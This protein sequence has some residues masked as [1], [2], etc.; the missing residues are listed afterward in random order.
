MCPA[1]I[2]TV[3]WIAAGTA[4]TGGLSAL[5]VS[6]FHGKMLRGKKQD[7]TTSKNNMEKGERDGRQEGNEGEY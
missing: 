2:A 6:S 5:A 4:S 7:S 1:C 3:A